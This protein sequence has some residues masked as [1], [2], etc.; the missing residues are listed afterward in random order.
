MEPKQQTL[1]TVGELIAE[2]QKHPPESPVFATWEGTVHKILIL[3]P[4]EGWN[5]P[6]GTVLIDAESGPRID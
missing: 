5:L 1:N 2:L 6:P 3:I 4:T